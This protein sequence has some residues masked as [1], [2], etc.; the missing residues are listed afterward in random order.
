[1]GAANVAVVTGASRGL[2]RGIAIALG[3]AGYLVYVTA[4]SATKS[5]SR[6]SGTLQQTAERAYPA[7]G[8]TGIAV[9]CDHGDDAQ[10]ELLFGRVKA[11]Q[12]RLDV[13]VNNAF[14]MPDEM[15]APGL[16]WERPLDAWR[17]VIDIG[18]RSSFVA[19]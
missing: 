14:G 17:Q 15:A 9:A 8:G 10:T 12:G 7:A 16:F 3:A 1:M 13:L 2:G 4:R 6:W 5:T 11:E 19:S 18:L